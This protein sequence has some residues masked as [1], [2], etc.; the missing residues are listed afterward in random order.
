VLAFSTS[1]NATVTNAA[2]RLDINLR[3][4]RIKIEGERVGGGGWGWLDLS[5]LGTPDTRKLLCR[6]SLRRTLFCG[7]GLG[8][9][10]RP[11]PALCVWG[12]WRLALSK[13]V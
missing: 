13:G 10:R 9:F 1:T 4:I 7:P 6:A 2:V 12:S 5:S 8:F 3:V 11:G